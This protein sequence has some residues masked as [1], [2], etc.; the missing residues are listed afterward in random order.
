MIKHYL[1]FTA[2]ISTG[3]ILQ[4]CRKATDSSEAESLTSSNLASDKTTGAHSVPDNGADDYQVYRNKSFSGEDDTALPYLVSSARK[5]F[6][7]ARSIL[8]ELVLRGG[9]TEA[10]YKEFGPTKEKAARALLEKCLNPDDQI[11]YSLAQLLRESPES[12][13]DERQARV[14]LLEIAANG[15]TSAWSEL[16]KIAFET[17]PNAEFNEAHY[18]LLLEAHVVSPDSLRGEQIWDGLKKCKEHLSRA[19]LSE[20][21]AKVDEYF[22]IYRSLDPK[23][24]LEGA[25]DDAAVQTAKDAAKMKLD[26]YRIECAGKANN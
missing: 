16:S 18:W 25:T 21:W 22:G 17:T 11:K 9:I 2:I 8:S 3:F 10:G 7:G 26:A 4:S 6:A 14:L 19:A 13:D 15:Y 23:P 5:G 12:A 20:S 1:F 24:F